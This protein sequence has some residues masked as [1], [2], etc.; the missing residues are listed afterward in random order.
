MFEGLAGLF[1]SN[2]FWSALL[3]VVALVVANVFEVELSGEE[4]A[5][6]LTVIGLLIGGYSLEDSIRRGQI[7]ARHT[8]A[9][10]ASSSTLITAAQLEDFYRRI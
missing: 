10:K 4:I 1:K 3:G 7:V 6:I 5:S 8:C 2:R 9:Q